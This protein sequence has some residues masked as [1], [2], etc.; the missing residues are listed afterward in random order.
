MDSSAPTSANTPLQIRP[1]P[2]EA[3]RTHGPATGGVKKGRTP[4]E[5]AARPATAGDGALGTGRARFVAGR[6]WGCRLRGK[7]GFRGWTGSW[8]SRTCHDHGG[9]RSR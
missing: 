4:L 6:H 9:P 1:P 3:Y 7:E 2:E 8:G 5:G